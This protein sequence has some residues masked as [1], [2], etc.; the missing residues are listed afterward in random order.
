MS[1]T[2]YCT[3]CNFKDPGSVYCKI[4]EMNWPQTYRGSS[5]Y[6]GW[7]RGTLVC[8]NSIS[9]TKGDMHFRHYLYQRWY[10]TF[11]FFKIKSKSKIKVVDKWSLHILLHPSHYWLYKGGCSITNQKNIKYKIYKKTRKEDEDN[12]VA[13]GSLHTLLHSLDRTRPSMLIWAFLKG[14]SFKY[15]KYMALELK[16]WI[17]HIF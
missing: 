9:L 11:K 3:Q 13:K 17:S 12:I 15:V 4:L 14:N 2:N 10:S 1:D 5:Y 16:W 8:N 6:V 7:M